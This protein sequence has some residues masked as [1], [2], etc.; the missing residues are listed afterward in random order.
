MRVDCS[1]SLCIQLPGPVHPKVANYVGQIPSG[2]YIV[3]FDVPVL[4]QGLLTG[5]SD[6]FRVGRLLE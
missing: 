1:L 3:V 6:A 4:S 2:T 5:L